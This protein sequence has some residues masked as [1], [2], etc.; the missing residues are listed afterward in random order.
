MHPCWTHLLVGKDRVRAAPCKMCTDVEVSECRSAKWATVF[1]STPSAK[2]RTHNFVRLTSG[3]WHGL[4]VAGRG[5]GIGCRRKNHLPLRLAVS[6]LRFP[7]NESQNGSRKHTGS[8][9]PIMT[10]LSQ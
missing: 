4:G 3:G 6:L 5:G 9:K 8:P 10:L 1:G 7:S 2:S